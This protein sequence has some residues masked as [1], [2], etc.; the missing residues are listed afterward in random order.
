M[1]KKIQNKNKFSILSSLFCIFINFF[2][3]TFSDLGVKIKK[4]H[5]GTSDSKYIKLK[6]RKVKNKYK[7]GH[8]HLV[9]LPE[10]QNCY[11]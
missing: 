1:I 10:R 3:F 7:K 5:Q 2:L 4:T 11:Y 9:N 6:K 8:L